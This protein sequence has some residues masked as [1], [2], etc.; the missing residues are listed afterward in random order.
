MKENTGIVEEVWQFLKVE[1]VN[2]ALYGSLAYV[3]WVVGNFSGFDLPTWISL[4]WG[5]EALGEPLS[6]LGVVLSLIVIS[7]A[8]FW[9]V[10]KAAVA[11]VAV[12]GCLV[13]LAILG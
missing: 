4:T 1:G 10:L 11:V 7:F 2:A 5:V 13:M 8:W 12:I 6:A 9:V 3:L